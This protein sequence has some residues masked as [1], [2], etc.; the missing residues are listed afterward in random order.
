MFEKLPRFQKERRFLKKFGE[1]LQN[2]KV[3]RFGSDFCSEHDKN[4]NGAIFF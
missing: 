2:Y 1:F 3:L 4:I